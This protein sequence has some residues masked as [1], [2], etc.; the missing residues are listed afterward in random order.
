MSGIRCGNGAD[1]EAGARADD[2]HGRVGVRFATT[3]LAQIAAR[4]VRNGKSVG[5]EVVDDCETLQTE[6]G[7]QFGDGERPGIVGEAHQVG[8]RARRHR[9][10]GARWLGAV[11]LAQVGGESVGER[12]MVLAEKRARADDSAVRLNERETCIGGADVADQP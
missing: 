12:G 4:E 7:L 3:D 9:E 11:M 8:L 6:L 5:V 1:A 2:A 10:N